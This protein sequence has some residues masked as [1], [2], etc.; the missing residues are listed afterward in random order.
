[1]SASRWKARL[2]MR[3]VSFVPGLC[4]LSPP[5]LP[6]PAGGR[7]LSDPRSFRRSSVESPGWWSGPLT[8]SWEGAGRCARTPALFAIAPKL[9]HPQLL[10]PAWRPFQAWTGIVAPE[11]WSFLLDWEN[12]FLLLGRQCPQPAG[13][14]HGPVPYQFCK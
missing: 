5:R 1:M 9:L 2:P 14:Y 4:F 7:P 10:P 8:F 3:R 12:S 13:T 11:R 6:L